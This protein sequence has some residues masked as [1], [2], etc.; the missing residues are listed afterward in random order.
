MSRPHSGGHGVDS[1]GERSNKNKD[2][3]K[4]PGKGNEDG[5]VP[6]GIKKNLDRL[7]DQN[8]WKERLAGEGEEGENSEGGNDALENEL[9]G[10]AE[11]RKNELQGM[12]ESMKN[13][14]GDDEAEVGDEEAE[15]E[16]PPPAATEITVPETPQE[17]QAV[18]AAVPLSENPNL[19]QQEQEAV[20]KADE[21]LAGL[22]NPPPPLPDQPVAPLPKAL[23][24][25]A[26]AGSA[27]VF[28]PQQRIGAPG[29]LDGVID[30][31]AAGNSSGFILQLYSNIQSNLKFD[32]LLFNSIV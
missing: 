10:M 28:A 30:Q 20:R 17:A 12:T 4:K 32:E 2:K 27:G 5:F 11:S 22:V 24:P 13:A 29:I 21:I 14:G 16:Q 8:P 1:H 18:Q 3:G 15:G 26:G 31:A 7:P 6:P 25:Q 23:Q 9:A 19:S